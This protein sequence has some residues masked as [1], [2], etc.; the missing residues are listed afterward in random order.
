MAITMAHITSATK[1]DQVSVKEGIRRFG[2]KA[3]DAVLS[4]YAQLKDKNVFKPRF[5]NDLT[6]QQQKD[7]LNLITVVKEKR[8]G[9][10]KGRAVADG[11]KQ[12]KYIGK[13]ESTSPTIHLQSLLLSLMI[14][15]VEKRDVGTAD[16][17]GAYLL[18]D[19]KGFVLVKLTGESV[20]V[21]CKCD[22]EYE[23]YVTYEKGKKVLYMELVKALYGCIM[24]ALLWYETFVGELQKMGFVINPYDP[25]VANMDIEGSQCTVCWYVDDTK[26]S[27]KNPEVVTMI[28]NKFEKLFHKLTI[29]RGKEHTF[30]GMDFEFKENGDLQIHMKEYLNECISAYE[31]IDGK[32]VGEAKTPAKH[33]LFYVN[34]E[35][36]KLST[37]KAEVFH[38]IVA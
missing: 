12:R 21:M 15:A 16:I 5:A 24:P 19:M 4:E 13:E 1:H 3:I 30:V 2:S 9:K 25:C 29:K 34:K 14:D 20:E 26:V 32:L 33:D 18:A 17:A 28:L 8:C 7:A 38:H 6:S 23:K 10:I 11:R 31:E 36:Q 37:E 22:P 35:S 27:H